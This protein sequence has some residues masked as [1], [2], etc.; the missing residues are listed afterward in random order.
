MLSNDCMYEMSIYPTNL[1]N[2]TVA[3]VHSIEKEVITD[4]LNSERR[5]V[6]FSVWLKYLWLSWVL[7]D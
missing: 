4:V 3:L 6:P 2:D 5:L 1:R 7:Q